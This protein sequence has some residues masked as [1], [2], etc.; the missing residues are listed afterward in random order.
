VLAQGTV[1]IKLTNINIIQQ[2]PRVPVNALRAQ[3]ARLSL[4]D[5]DLPITSL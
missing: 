4:P 2:L 1:H 5:N 3:F